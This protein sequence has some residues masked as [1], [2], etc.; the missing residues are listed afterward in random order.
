MTRARTSESGN[1]RWAL[2]PVALLLASTLGV[3]SMALIAIRDPNFATEPDY[4]N[5][6][7]HWDQTQ[8]QAAENQR[9]GYVVELEPR[10]VVDAAGR[11]TLQL[12]LQDAT[13][14]PVRGAVVTAVAFANA[15]S[16][17]VSALAFRELAP[18]VYVAQLAARHLGLWEFRV[19]ATSG[20][21]HIT[22]T[23]RRD[24]VRGRA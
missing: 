18:G 3:G 21:D 17:D 6:A 2:V 23:L 19:T 7:L 13:R 16:G 9:L 1:S 5:K 24:V 12:K 22:Q 15:F 20:K 14:A 8:A 11:A 4:Y 10:V